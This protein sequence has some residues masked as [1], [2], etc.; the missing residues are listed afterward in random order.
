MLKEKAS[1]KMRKG[2]KLWQKER[3]ITGI[4]AK[5]DD[6]KRQRNIQ[7]ESWK[8]GQVGR[9]FCHLGKEQ[10]GQRMVKLREGLA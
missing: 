10:N 3:H 4:E 1:K 7:L 2:M 6:F 5:E 9:N 8:I